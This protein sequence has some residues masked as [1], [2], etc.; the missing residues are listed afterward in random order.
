MEPTMKA[1]RSF[2]VAHGRESTGRVTIAMFEDRMIVGMT[3]L[4]CTVDMHL[5]LA[6]VEKLTATLVELLG[7]AK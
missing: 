2:D 1:F 7:S 6:E 4:G 5:T 3:T